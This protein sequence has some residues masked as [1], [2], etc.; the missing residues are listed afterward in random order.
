MD[1]FKKSLVCL[2]LLAATGQVA[3]GQVVAQP[4]DFPYRA[5]VVS[6]QAMVLSGPGPSHYGTEVLSEG[7]EVEVYRH[8]PG[9]WVAIRPPASSF[10]L[11]QRDEV[12]IQDDGSAEVV[13]PQALAWV[14]TRLEPVEKPL[15]QVKLRRG[16][17]VQV[18]GAVDRDE[19]E[20]GAD[21]P[22]WIQIEPPAG[23]FRWIAAG[24]IESLERDEPGHMM[25]ED[26]PNPSFPE[27]GSAAENAETKP[28]SRGNSPANTAP[29][30]RQPPPH[31]ASTDPAPFDEW[32]PIQRQVPGQWTMEDQTTASNEHPL[33]VAVANPPTSP[34][35]GGWQP[36]RQTISNFVE[37]R[38]RFVSESAA[39]NFP[40]DTFAQGTLS[41]P[42]VPNMRHTRSEIFGSFDSAATFPVAQ[43][44]SIQQPYPAA[45]PPWGNPSLQSLEMRLTQEMLKQPAEWNLFPLAAELESIR[46]TSLTAPDQD[47][48]NRLMDRIRQCRE[49][50]AGYRATGQGGPADLQGLQNRGMVANP[51]IPMAAPATAMQM[52]APGMSNSPQGDGMLYNYD[53]HGYLNELVRDGGLAPKTYVLQDETGKVTHHIAA[54][55][56]VNLRPYLNQRVGIIGNRGFH[57]QLQLNH[58]TAE[59]VIALDT[60]RR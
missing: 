21:Q 59:R 16:E 32:G 3:T 19:F 28:L 57:Q 33:V 29:G 51:A 8:D 34:T 45:P 22:D 53:A 37:E 14:G 4:A 11:V 30:W 25:A 39:A 48:I 15:W 13:Q 23:E 6:E 58:V 44:S 9:G 7:T 46:G 31:Q 50:Q 47:Q 35:G 26:D 1:T 41:S 60:L 54:L 2:C 5:V 49:I 43:A 17:T 36:A 18:L 42:D 40:Q 56:G 12:E 20:L 27:I 38:S 10:S 52:T 55:P 24:D